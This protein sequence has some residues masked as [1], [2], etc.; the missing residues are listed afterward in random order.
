[1]GSEMCIRDRNYVVQSAID[2]LPLP[3]KLQLVYYLKG[4]VVD[5][6]RNPYGSCALDKIID[7]ASF[8]DLSFLS[9]VTNEIRGRV[10][11]LSIDKISSRVI[12]KII[13][14]FPEEFTRP[15]LEVLHSSTKAL[16]SYG[17]GTWIL[18]EIMKRSQHDSGRIISA[19]LLYT[20]PSP[21][22]LSTS[23]MPS[24]A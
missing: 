6:I 22:D 24:S 7:P 23:R 9:F 8:M 11:H 5:I 16:I 1:M 18:E 19:C 10:I 3:L 13:R 20:S 4:A 14:V 12:Q 2:V 17:A 21:R 15:I